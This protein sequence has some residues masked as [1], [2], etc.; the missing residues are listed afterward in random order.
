[1]GHLVRLTPEVKWG[2]SVNRM[3]ADEITPEV[4]QQKLECLGIHANMDECPSLQDTD[5]E[6]IIVL[7]RRWGT[8][9]PNGYSA[10]YIDLYIRVPISHSEAYAIPY[11]GDD[12]APVARYHHCCGGG[13]NDGSIVDQ[14]WIARHWGKFFYVKAFR[15]V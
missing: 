5:D 11:F 2:F 1:M 9:Y 12:P 3:S 4:V 8:T 14:E 7:V 10:T 15:E 13:C 6:K